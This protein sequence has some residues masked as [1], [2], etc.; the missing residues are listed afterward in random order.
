ML[1]AFVGYFAFRV[2]ARTVAFSREALYNKPVFVVPYNYLCFVLVG[3]KKKK[4]KAPVKTR[5]KGD[6]AFYFGLMRFCEGR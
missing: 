6:D 4:R 2:T 5:V 1:R 3:N